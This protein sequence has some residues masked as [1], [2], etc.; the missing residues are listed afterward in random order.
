MQIQRLHKYRDRSNTE[1]AEFVEFA[2]TKITDREFYIL[3]R[4]LDISPTFH[5]M[6]RQVQRSYSLQIQ[7]SQEQGSHVWEHR[8]MVQKRFMYSFILIHKTFNI[9]NENKPR[10]NIK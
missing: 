6:S 4:R 1:I 7:R 8:I 3:L 2:D 5:N 9:I 10:M